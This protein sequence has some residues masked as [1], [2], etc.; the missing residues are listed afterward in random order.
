MLGRLGKRRDV[1]NFLRRARVNVLG[2]AKS[3][4]ENRIFGKMRKDAQLDLGI[5]GGKQNVA[6]LGDEGGANFAAELGANR[7]VLQIGIRGAETSGGGA[8]LIDLRVQAASVRGDELVE[9]VRIRGIEFRDFAIIH[10][11]LGQ[12]VES[13]QFGEDFRSEE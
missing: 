5:I 7:N 2:A 9:R 6:R 11:Q 1:E 8:S 4:D 10:H 13:S 12:F 3:F